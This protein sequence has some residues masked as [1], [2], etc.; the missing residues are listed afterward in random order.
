MFAPGCSARRA[1]AGRT[2]ASRWEQRKFDPASLHGWSFLHDAQISDATGE[3][4]VVS[5]PRLTADG[6]S[7][8]TRVRRVDQPT[9]V[10]EDWTWV[11]HDRIR[12]RRSD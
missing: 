2:S 12:V 8:H 4:E 10:V 3:Q 7:V 9:A 1:N 5:L 11:A 6:Q